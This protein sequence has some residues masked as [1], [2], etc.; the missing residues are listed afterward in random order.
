MSNLFFFIY[1]KYF[2]LLCALVG[3]FYRN[4]LKTFNALI[5]PYFLLL[6]FISEYIGY[7]LIK[8][9]AEKISRYMF[10]YYLLPAQILF[11]IWFIAIKVL[12]KSKIAYG[13]IGLFLLV[14]IIEIFIGKSNPDYIFTKTYGLGG[15]LLS[16]L[17][18]L[19]IL[20]ITRDDKV[21]KFYQ[22]LYFWICIGVA[23]Y[24]TLSFPFYTYY[25]TL[26]TNHKDVFY[27]YR[28]IINHFSSCMYLLF[29]IGFIWSKKI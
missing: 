13:L 12:N 9:G 10:I 17:F 29:I 3:F 11:Y 25:N 22:N 6:V 18:L 19:F 7:Y 21:L 14:F 20:K 24:Y 8:H 5:L 23:L 28:N 27:L 2:I 1:A 16:I 15:I 4:K 26:L